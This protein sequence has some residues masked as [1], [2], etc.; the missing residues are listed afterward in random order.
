MR[1][2]PCSTVSIADRSVESALHL[3]STMNAFFRDRYDA[4]KKLGEVLAPY[5]ALPRKQVLALPRGGVPVASEVA[6]ALGAPLDAFLVRKLGVPGCPEVAM[7]AVASGDVCVRHEPILRRCDIDAAA[8][9]RVRAA[10]TEELH[11]REVLYRGQRPPAAV[12]GRHVFLIDDGLATGASMRAALRA[13]RS[14][15]PAGIVVAV[16]VGSARAEAVLRDESEADAVVCLE[17]P[18][19]F[20][21]VSLAYEHFA[22]TSDDEVRALIGKPELS[23]TGGGR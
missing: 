17:T 21:A 1:R 5:R 4:G 8:F 3:A 6:R 11:R 15:A 13:V 23:K 18:D 19:P 12:F 16:P 20:F 7:G 22:P 14:L 10:E 9:E 2:K